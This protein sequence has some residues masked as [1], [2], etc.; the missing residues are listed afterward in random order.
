MTVLVI[1][2]QREKS[3]LSFYKMFDATCSLIIEVSHIALL[4]TPNRTCVI[5]YSEAATGDS[6][7]TVE[8]IGFR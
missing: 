8:V 4:I 3:I 1:I 5:S 2:R 6:R 7:F